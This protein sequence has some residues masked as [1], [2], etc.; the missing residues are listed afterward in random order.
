MG[1]L[2]AYSAAFTRRVGVHRSFALFCV[3]A[4]ISCLVLG[5]TSLALPSVISVLI[6]RLSNTLF[7]PLLADLQNRQ[8]T[9][10][11]RATAL[12]VCGMLVNGIA[13]G[14]NLVFGAL[15][16]WNLSAAFYFGSVICTVGLLLFWLWLKTGYG[17]LSQDTMRS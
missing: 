12:S 5:S 16:D 1:L 10:R 2:G 6:L 4:A 13:I 17:V 9:S 7:Q 11:N 14:T 8:I 3:L 15:S